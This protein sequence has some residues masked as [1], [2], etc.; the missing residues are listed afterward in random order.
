MHTGRW[1]RVDDKD[2]L[3]FIKYEIKGQSAMLLPLKDLPCEVQ[4]AYEEYRGRNESLDS[5][6]LRGSNI[7][8]QAILILDSVSGVAY[9]TRD[10][11]NSF[12]ASQIV[13]TL[14]LSKRSAPAITVH[15]LVA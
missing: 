4:T 9:T 14:N 7:A 13:E 12:E 3:Q 5:L 8:I 10:G 11:G 1:I 6:G 15:P 2:I